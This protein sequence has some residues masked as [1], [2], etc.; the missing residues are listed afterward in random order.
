MSSTRDGTF[1]K[2]GH[3]N[4]LN[5][6]GGGSKFLDFLLG[7]LVRELGLASATYLFSLFLRVFDNMAG[8]R[9]KFW[10]NDT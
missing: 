2:N 7:S 9:T 6:S 5:V 8:E 10:L 3:F 4:G 1:D